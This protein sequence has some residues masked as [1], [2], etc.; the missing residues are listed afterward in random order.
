[1]RSGRGSQAHNHR[2]R[3]PPHRVADPHSEEQASAALPLDPTIHPT[4]VDLGTA[5][6]SE[7]TASVNRR[8]IHYEG[9]QELDE[10][11]ESGID[12]DSFV[13]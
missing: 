6:G 4:V 2:H 10:H 1:M 13:C 11:L 9:N 12:L 7:S 5:T 3:R 8:P